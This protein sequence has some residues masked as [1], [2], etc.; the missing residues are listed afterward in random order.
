MGRLDIGFDTELTQNLGAN[1]TDRAD[2]NFLETLP[3]GV[4]L[5]TRSGD[6]HEM[7][8]LCAVGKQRNIDSAGNNLINCAAQRR[9]ILGQSPTIDWNRSY[10]CT[11]LLQS[12]DKLRIGDAIFLDRDSFAADIFAA[13]SVERISRQVLASGT[14]SAACSANS[15]NAAIGLGPRATSWSL[16]R[17]RLILSCENWVSKISLSALCRRRS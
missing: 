11:A 6:L 4:G 5:V 12:S 16:L 7:I 2:G 10:D 8:D 14:V 13:S 15:F 9:Q 3:Q 17:P 1:R